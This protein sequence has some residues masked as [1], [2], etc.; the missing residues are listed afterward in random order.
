MVSKASVQIITFSLSLICKIIERNI[1]QSPL[2]EY[3]IRTGARAARLQIAGDKSTDACFA[4][5][6]ILIISPLLHDTCEWFVA[7]WSAAQSF[8]SGSIL[9][10]PHEGMLRLENS[11][12]W[13]CSRNW[14]SSDKPHQIA[15]LIYSW[16]L[17][18]LYPLSIF[19]IP[20]KVS[21]ACCWTK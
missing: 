4:A 14:P 13:Y 21:S 12:V 8:K 7:A 3:L 5:S 11:D 19:L 15:F 10:S 1:T 18:P 16:P 2:K 9:T 17:L 20:L 6:Q